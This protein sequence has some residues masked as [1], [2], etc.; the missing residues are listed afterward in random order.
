M[1]YEEIT[2]LTRI[3]VESGVTSLKVTGGEPLVRR[4]WRIWF[5]C[6]AR[7]GDDLDISIS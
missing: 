1:T 6:C 4:M 7:I 5:G 2:R 3:L